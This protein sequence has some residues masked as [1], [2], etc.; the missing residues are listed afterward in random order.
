MRKRRFE[1]RIRRGIFHANETSIAYEYTAIVF[2][3]S[4][5][6][7]KGLADK[8]CNADSEK[9]RTMSTIKAFFNIKP[10]SW[11]FDRS[12]NC[13]SALLSTYC[14]QRNQFAPQRL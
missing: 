7:P 12:A 14:H 2:R 13:R 5:W 9:R 8:F 3:D 1:R 10:S 6:A 4:L 11:L